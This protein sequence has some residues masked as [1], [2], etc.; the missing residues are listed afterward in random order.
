MAK[1]KIEINIKQ[2][3]LDNELANFLFMGRPFWAPIG[4]H[5]GLSMGLPLG[6][7]RASLCVL[8]GRPCGPSMSFPLGTQWACF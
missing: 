3:V 8:S 7:Q 2:K 6:S 4:P 5:F 1:V